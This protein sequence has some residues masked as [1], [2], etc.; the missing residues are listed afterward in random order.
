MNKNNNIASKDKD[1]NVPINGEF[2]I[3]N[4]PAKCSGVRCNELCIID[5]IIKRLYK[6]E[7]GDIRSG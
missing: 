1:G 7:H 6:F 2:K 3:C 5:Q 4:I